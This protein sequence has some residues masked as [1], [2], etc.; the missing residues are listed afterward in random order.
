MNPWTFYMQSCIKGLLNRIIG[1]NDTENVRKERSGSCEEPSSSGTDV[2][3]S[4][5]D[6]L[7]ME[8]IIEILSCLNE[9]KNDSIH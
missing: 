9:N 4:K 8:M 7:P 5:L 2:R 1:E 3:P 6:S